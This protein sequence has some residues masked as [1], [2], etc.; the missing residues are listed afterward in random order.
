MHITHSLRLFLAAAAL[1]AGLGA[2]ASVSAAAPDNGGG[3]TP[4]TLCHFVPAHGGSYVVITVDDDAATGNK[5]LQGHMGH[6][7][8]I[9]PAN[10]DGTCGTPDLPPD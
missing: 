4:I 3:H 10:P 2:A 5:N 9:I 7:D 1:T 6:A 8:D